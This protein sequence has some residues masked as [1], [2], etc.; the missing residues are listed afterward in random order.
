MC[1][2]HFIPNVWLLVTMERS[3]NSF[4]LPATEMGTSCPPPAVKGLGGRGG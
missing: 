3:H 1:K 4:L 2:S